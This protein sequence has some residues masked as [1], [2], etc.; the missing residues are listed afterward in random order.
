MFSHRIQELHQQGGNGLQLTWE[1]KFIKIQIKW[2][3]GQLLIL[4]FLYLQ[5][6]FKCR[7]KNFPNFGKILFGLKKDHKFSP[8]GV[9]LFYLLLN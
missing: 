2:Q 4:T 7:K 6:S 8:T 5:K 3:N 9:F 1:L